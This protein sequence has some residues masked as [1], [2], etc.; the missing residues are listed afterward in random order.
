MA[1]LKLT[2]T[3][4]GQS[5]G[6]TI[7]SPSA[8]T[9]YAL[10]DFDWGNYSPDLNV[11][12]RR[13]GSLK[14]GY[15]TWQPRLVQLGV[16]ASGVSRDAVTL[17]KNAL[18]RE[19]LACARAGGTL[20]WKGNGATYPVNF[21]VVA[22]RVMWKEGSQAT[23]TQFRT[24]GVIELDVDPAALGD[25]MGFVDTFDSDTISD[26]TADAGAGTISVGPAV[27]VVSSTAAKR[28]RHTARG[29]AYTDVQATLRVQTGSVVTN[30]DWAIGIRASTS[31]A[32]TMLACRVSAAAGQLQAVKVVAGVVT[33]LATGALVPAVST[34]YWLRARIEGAL[35]VCDAFTVEPT[36][37]STPSVTVSYVLSAAEA[38][39]FRSGHVVIRVTPASTGETY[40]ELAVVPYC[41]R[42]SI[43]TP[44]VLRLVGIPGDIAALADVDI[45]QP[46]GVNTAAAWG[47]AA[48]CQRP[49]P[50]DL[51]GNG[52]FEVDTQGW[53]VAGV[54]GVTGAATSIALDATTKKYGSQSG[55]ITCPATANTGAL[56]TIRRPF[57]RGSVYVACG[58][59][60]AAAGA[61]NARF[62]LGVSGDI[63]SSTGAA[64]AV[65]PA[66]ESVVWRPTATV[67]QAY[68][69]AEITAATA[70][71]F[72]VDGIDVFEALPTTLG[73]AML[74]GDTTMTVTAQPQEAVQTPFVCLVDNELVQVLDAST[75]VWSVR[76]GVDGTTPAAH[77]SAAGVYVWPG[78]SRDWVDGANGNALCD[79]MEAEGGFNL[80]NLAV[81]VDANARNGNKLA[82]SS[83]QTS[84][85]AQW[86]IDPG[87][88]T[89]R[90]YSEA[91]QLI[92]VWARVELVST[93]TTPRIITSAQ[94][95]DGN[96]FAA[97]RYD[98][99]N[100]SAGLVPVLP[101]TGTVWRFMR[102]GVVP[103]LIDPD[104]R[105]RRVALTV[106]ITVGAAVA[107]GV[108]IDYLVLVDPAARVAT[109]T[110]VGYVAG[111][112]PD[113]YPTN[114][115]T[116]RRVRSDLVSLLGRPPRGLVRSGG[117]IGS[118]VQIPV[119]NADMLVKLSR[120]IPNDPS[121]IATTEDGSSINSPSYA[122]VAVSVNPTP[123]YLVIR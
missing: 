34:T 13:D 89:P 17:A 64:L 116:T 119:P 48:W 95:E 46:A 53:S 65:A 5:G 92:E 55:K 6:V 47:M 69:A 2:A 109:P 71:V 76:R 63:A 1:L 102:L 91:E 56:F 94:S 93:L 83:S 74:A 14:A 121:S 10:L 18:T 82:P 45:T 123:R 36:P 28:L 27:L 51:V 23:E 100:G 24:D 118:L 29:Y 42:S 49:L 110:G 73:V 60:F 61:V 104:A 59:R 58:W 84:F 80:T 122:N 81:T 26:Y 19:A 78:R 54:A 7:L 33:T 25:P 4:G 16:R 68:F 44:D 101:S 30:G 77:A 21:R 98:I 85:S 113:F 87:T 117:V 9:A 37:T 72:N 86:M 99:E 52:N 40:D 12:T 107:A 41:Y 96:S 79:V 50:V 97:A 20:R 103:V 3:A 31:G 106:Q 38:D 90:D 43:T 22:A 75:L 66:F 112:Y 57:R 35:L 115:E 11:V 70:Q 120:L 111:T 88:L 15:P 39:Q 67:S 62:R 8:A 114:G 105:R 32:D 108:G